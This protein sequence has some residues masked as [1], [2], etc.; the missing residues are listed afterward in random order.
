MDSVKLYNLKYKVKQRQDE[1]IDDAK[2][3]NYSSN[4]E[5]N[6]IQDCIRF[7]GIVLQDL[8]ELKHDK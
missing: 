8:E 1:L 6:L 7:F 5:Y 3:G 2:N 4:Q